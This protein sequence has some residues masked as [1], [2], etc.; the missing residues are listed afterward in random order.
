[1]NYEQLLVL[2]ILINCAQLLLVGRTALFTKSGVVQVRNSGVMPTS[3]NNAKWIVGVV[4][5]VAGV[6]SKKFI[7]PLPHLSLLKASTAHLLTR[8]ML[9]WWWQG[10]WGWLCIAMNGGDAS[11]K[12]HLFWARIFGDRHFLRTL[13]QL[14]RLL[15]D[16][17]PYDGIPPLN[18]SDLRH[19]TPLP[20]VHW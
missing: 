14:W 15:S 11:W 3:V 4:G 12:M 8:T 17:Q 6:C 7:P 5:I 10:W 20:L 1:M 13:G 18:S 16:S 9:A 19:P 2:F